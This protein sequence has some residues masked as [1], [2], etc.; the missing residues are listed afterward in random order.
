MPTDIKT[1]VADDKNIYAGTSNGKVVAIPIKHL[2]QELITSRLPEVTGT[3]MPDE[4]T[5]TTV[6][7][8]DGI[9]QEQSAISLHAQKDER[10]K[11]LLHIPLPANSKLREETDQ[12][13]QAM[14]YSSLPDLASSAYR[15]GPII[16][17]PLFKSL[18]V[19]AGKGH[20]EYSTDVES[21]EETSAARERNE[22]F[23]LLVWGHRNT[24]S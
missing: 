23:Q 8:T 22:A 3:E 17:Q 6:E 2:R 16:T 21:I 19:S 10:V 9:F 20:V 18:I 13:S 4:N 14:A 5:T 15:G 24:I 12:L 11:T 7:E 1:I